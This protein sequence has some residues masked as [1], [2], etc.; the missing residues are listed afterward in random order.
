MIVVRSNG[1]SS[2]VDPG[3]L[4]PVGLVWG[5][6]MMAIADGQTRTI[7]LSPNDGKRVTVDGWRPLSWSPE[8]DTLLVNDAAT[9]RTLGLLDPDQGSVQE[10][11]RLTGPVF[12]VHWLP[13]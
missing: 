9:G 12:D 2:E 11:A 10:I 3:T 5:M 4:D 7:L 1:S 8:G 6:R 13:G